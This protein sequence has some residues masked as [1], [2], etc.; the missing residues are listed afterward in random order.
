MFLNAS[1]ACAAVN[2]QGFHIIVFNP[3]IK[4]NSHYLIE[5]DVWLF[6]KSVLREKWSID[7]EKI[8]HEKALLSWREE[9]NTS[10]IIQKSP[11]LLQEEDIILP[12]GVYFQN[13]VAAISG[14]GAGDNEKFAQF[15][16]IMCHVESELAFAKYKNN[17][18]EA[19][20]A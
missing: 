11:H 4:Y 19:I 13:T 14:L 9:M 10:E 5:K 15:F 17:H 20:Y 7:H 3:A 18:A 16:I 6:S 2:T 8:A 1:S 12:G